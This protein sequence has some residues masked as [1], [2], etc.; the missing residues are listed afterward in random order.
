MSGISDS[1]HEL[2]IQQDPS[3]PVAGTSMPG[4]SGEDSSQLVVDWMKREVFERT[5]VLAAA[6]HELKTPIAVIAGY[7]D[8]LLG[9]HLGDLSS[10]Q[11]E[12]V[13][14]IQQNAIRLQLFTGSFLHFSTIEAGHLL[15]TKE[16]GSVNE[17]VS[18][19]I[20]R[21]RGLFTSRGTELSFCPSSDLPSIFFDHIKFEHVISNLL[22]NALKFTPPGGRVVV[23]TRGYWWERRNSDPAM[24]AEQERRAG[25]SAPAVNSVRIDVADSGPGIAPEHHAE[26]FKEFLQ[27]DQG[28]HSHGVGL[29]LAVARRLVE[30]HGGRIWVESDRGKGSTF[31]LLLPLL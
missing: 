16:P 17:I 10:Q 13:R 26:I 23:T 24:P 12:V 29:G 3:K 15:I 19:G 11:R 5:F 6:A 27:L 8:L 4:T 25:A 1:Q 20:T 30:A 9:G 7:A 21:W 2:N 28:P 18:R 22:D 31:S 14:E